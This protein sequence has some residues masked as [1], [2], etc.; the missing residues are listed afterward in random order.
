MEQKSCMEGK[1]PQVRCPNI[2]FTRFT[3]G[4]YCVLCFDTSEI[5]EGAWLVKG[6][7]REERAR[8]RI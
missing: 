8:K 2:V 4:M 7:T 5:H 3:S 1:K 6:N